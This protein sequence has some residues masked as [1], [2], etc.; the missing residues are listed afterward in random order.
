MN[1]TERVLHI[2]KGVNSLFHDLN[3][4]EQVQT[5][6]EQEVLRLNPEIF[7][8]FGKLSS[9]NPM[10]DT[11]MPKGDKM[12]ARVRK[13][14]ADNLK[15][16]G[17]TYDPKTDTVTGTNIRQN[18]KK[19]GG[20]ITQRLSKYSIKP[21]ERLQQLMA[22]PFIKAEPVKPQKV[23]SPKEQ[24]AEVQQEPVQ[25]SSAKAPKQESKPEEKPKAKAPKSQRV[26]PK[27]PRNYKTRDYQVINGVKYNF[28]GS[29]TRPE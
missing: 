5:Q 3:I 2:R 8:E 18:L 1:L 6:G 22:D 13:E 24:K 19:M 16:A 21:T 15:K 29:F 4:I 17:I 26:K 23:E 14:L 25:V 12:S 20:D 11:F 7:T 9:S 10:I 27:D 28:H